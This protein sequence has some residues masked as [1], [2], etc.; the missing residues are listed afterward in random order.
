M[1]A[2]FRL[3]LCVGALVATGAASAATR[4]ANLAVGVTVTS[5]CLLNSADMDFGNYTPGAGNRTAM[6]QIRVSCTNGLAYTVGLGT[7]LAPSATEVTRR[8]SNGVSE[9]A[10]VL[11]NNPSRTQNWGQT[12]LADRVSGTGAGLSNDNLHRIY[13]RI[14]DTPANQAATAGLY[15]DTVLVT[16]TY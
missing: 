5:S 1:N 14:F 12:L 6:G 16:I 9:L 7:G 10:Y 3:A 8:M 4:T 11:F 13:G 15:T 2:N